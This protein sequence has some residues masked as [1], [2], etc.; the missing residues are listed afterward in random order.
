MHGGG[1]MEGA[2]F[3]YTVASKLVMTNWMLE[4]I[5]QLGKMDASKYIYY[6][7]Q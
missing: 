3:S 7:T 2:L 5:L 1:G 6:H 4:D